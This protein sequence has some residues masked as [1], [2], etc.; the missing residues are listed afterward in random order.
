MHVLA[1]QHRTGGFRSPRNP[2]ALAQ[3]KECLSDWSEDQVELFSFSEQEKLD[4][5][6]VDGSINGLGEQAQASVLLLATGQSSYLWF[7]SQHFPRTVELCSAVKKR[8]NGRIRIVVCATNSAAKEGLDSSRDHVQQLCEA[9]FSGPADVI[10]WGGFDS[11]YSVNPGGVKSLVPDK[12]IDARPQGHRFWP[13]GPIN[14]PILVLAL[15]LGFLLGCCFP[16]IFEE[17]VPWT[18]KTEKAA[19]GESERLHQRKEML[20]EKNKLAEE[21]ARI[22]KDGQ[23]AAIQSKANEEESERLHQAKDR[24]DEE[25]QTLAK[26]SKRLDKTQHAVVV[27]QGANE[28]ESER[29]GQRKEL[30]DKKNQT[31]AEK[32]KR[33]DEQKQAAILQ[34]RADERFRQFLYQEN[35]TL[36]GKSKMLHEE[37]R[38]AVL[39][40]REEKEKNERLHALLDKEKQTLAEKRKKLDEEKQAAVAQQKA[41]QDESERLRQRKDM[42][43]EK[44]QTLAEKSLRLETEKQLINSQKARNDEESKRLRKAQESQD[45]QSQ[46]LAKTCLLQDFKF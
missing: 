14:Y 18:D 38:S 2:A 35:Q 23:A 13:T 27:Q 15:L 5:S 21:A 42:L 39:H 46:M 6:K 34:E 24:L 29:L 19:V 45:E 1:I 26:R 17:L 7:N 44:D 12:K 10:V 3:Y 9:F 33:I 32:G 31:L 11:S 8:L 36:A 37:E 16:W 30:L 43:D 41:S 28:N 22:D 20:D 4:M 40:E 25:S